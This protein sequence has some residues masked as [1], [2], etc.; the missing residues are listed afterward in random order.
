MYDPAIGRFPSIDPIADQFP[1]ASTYNY[2]ENEPVGSIDLHGLQ[3]LKVNGIER[4]Q[5]E[6]KPNILRRQGA[7]VV[8]HPGAAIRIGE[9]RSGS[10]NISSVSSRIARHL[11]QGGDNLSEGEGTERNALRHGIWSA[12]IASE[13]GE[14]I[15]KRATDSHEGIGVA[16][17]SEVD[18]TKD[19]DSSDKLLGDQI[20][21]YLNNEIGREFGA[22]NEGSSSMDIAKG[23][24][25]IFKD[26]GL[27]TMTSDKDGNISIS[28]TKITQDQY[29][30][31]IKV[32][33]T[34]D[35]NGFDD[36]EKRSIDN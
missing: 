10:D 14:G 33:Q 11:A 4:T 1:H 34:L 21:D 23:I 20:V 7:F 16:A 29:D 8:R 27:Y 19:F 6:S 13:F 36:E 25:N 3:R 17:N 2:A 15:S 12:M 9:F 22:E 35:Q 24:L 5:A 18:F 26:E 32:L 28:K 31:A 30:N